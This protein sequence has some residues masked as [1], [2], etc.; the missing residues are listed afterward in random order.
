MARAM[1]MGRISESNEGEKKG[2]TSFGKAAGMGPMV[3]T[4]NLKIMDNVLQPRRAISGEG[5][6]A[7]ILEGV[8]KTIAIVVNARIRL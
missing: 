8:K 4:G 7:E 5:I 2:R 6:I 3:S 1:A